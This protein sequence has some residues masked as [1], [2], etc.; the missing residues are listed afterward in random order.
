MKDK[1]L[2]ILKWLICILYVGVMY[3]GGM[4]IMLLGLLLYYNRNL[5]CN[6]FQMCLIIGG[7]AFI[8]VITD[9]LANKFKIGVINE[10]S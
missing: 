10:R 1:L 7:G 5:Q 3:A 9:Y 2:K 4:M 6:N 8:S